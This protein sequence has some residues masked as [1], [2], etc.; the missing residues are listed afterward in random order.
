MASKRRIVINQKEEPQL[1]EGETW[2]QWFLRRYVR[3]WYWIGCIFLNVMM[4][5]TLWGAESLKSLAIIAIAFLFLVQYYVHT[6]LWGKKGR[7][8]VPEK[9]DSDQ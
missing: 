1:P 5:L 3:Y 7:F 9:E 8:A 6:L 2:K 4:A